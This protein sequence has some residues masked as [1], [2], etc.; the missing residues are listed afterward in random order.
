MTY[1]D[2]RK[3]I[4]YFENFHVMESN[5]D[6]FSNLFYMNYNSGWETCYKVT[7]YSVGLFQLIH[8]EE[9][10]E[11]QKFET[12]IKLIDLSN[13]KWLKTERQ[14]YVTPYVIT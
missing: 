2:G 4:D 3:P 8:E 9:V 12:P 7:Y 1:E 6:V 5:Q 14:C 11:C 10:V 13:Y